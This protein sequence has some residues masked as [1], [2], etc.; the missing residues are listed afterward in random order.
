MTS[1]ERLKGIDAFVATADSGSF[2]AAA[3][4]LKI[5]NSAVSKAVARLEQRLGTRLFARTTRS[6]SLTDAG[7]AFYRT[8]SKILADLEEAE[9]TLAAERLE[10]I[11]RLRVDVP[12]SFGRLHVLPVLLQFANDHPGLRPHISFSDH[13][14]DLIEE[15]IDVVVRIGGPDVW[16]A[17]LGH[18]YLGSERVIFCASPAY[19]QKRGPVHGVDDLDHHDCIV[20]KK[21]DGAV[22]AWMFRDNTG[23]PGTRRVI[24]GRVAVANGEAEVAAVVAGC[25]IAQLPTW[26]A[27]RELESGEIVEVLPGLATTG[28]PLTLLWPRSK[29]SLP[30][31]SALIDRLAETLTAAK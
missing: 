17:S 19:L 12:A 30:K 15:E 29:Q 22:T 23:G 14:V 21:A 24:D 16:A 27:Q 20:Y 4:R 2:T 9:A 11:G 28:L 5:T 7:A 13:F 6:L 10:P 3:A 18:R 31:V 8:C 25:G 26:L 1:P